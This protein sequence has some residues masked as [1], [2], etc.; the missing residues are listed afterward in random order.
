MAGVQTSAGT[1]IGI[2]SGTPATFDDDGFAALTYS[3]IG[4][5]TNLGEFG[6]EYTLVTHNPLANRGTVK[7]KGS[8]NSGQVTLQFA[9]DADDAGQVLLKTASGSD[10]DYNFEVT[11]Q[12]G[13]TEYFRAVVMSFKR[14]T[15]DVN[16]IRAGT[17]VLEITVTA[18]GVDFVNVPAA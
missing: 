5:V 18:A 11:Y 6:R 1:T 17:A 9:L 7:K 8:F 15:G 14:T 3:L 13:E 12:D 10:A 2:A 16:T 4:E